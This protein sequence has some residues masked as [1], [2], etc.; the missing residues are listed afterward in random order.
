MST[1]GSEEPGL[2][3]LPMPFNPPPG[4]PVPGRD[5]VMEYIGLSVTPNRRPD[6]APASDPE[7]WEWWIPQEPQ[8]TRW[9]AARR[10]FYRALTL[11]FGVVLVACIATA[12]VVGSDGFLIVVVGAMIA[13]LGLLVT[14]VR[15]AQFRK[16]PMSPVR[17]K[18]V[19]YQE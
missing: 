18:Y 1:P 4:W 3:D 17:E 2:R 6:G 7:R 12:F 9:M 8:W 5:W 15:W 16:D 10:R 14:S 13:G 19:G 11:G